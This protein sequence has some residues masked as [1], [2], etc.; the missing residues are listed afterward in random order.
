MSFKVKKLTVGKGKTVGDEKAGVWERQYFELEA[1]IE[2]ENALELAKGSLESLLDTWLKG[3]TI[4][5]EK[6]S[7]WNAGKIKWVQA[8]GSSGPYEKSEDVNSLDFKELLKDLSAH[9]GKLTRDGLFYWQFE[10]GDAV[11]R[12]PS[13]K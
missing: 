9:K 5:G 4:S 1:E 13:K 10:R 12:K 3:E 2:E 7:T 6:P 11:G 8:Q